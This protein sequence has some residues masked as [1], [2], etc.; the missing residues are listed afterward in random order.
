MLERGADRAQ[1][2]ASADLGTQ[3]AQLVFARHREFDVVDAHNLHALCVDDLLV[4]NITR[5]Q[6]LGRLQI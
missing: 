4:E 3:Q 6:E 1:Q 2:T 5:Q